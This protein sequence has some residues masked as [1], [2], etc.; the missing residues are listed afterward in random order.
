MRKL[1]MMQLIER[2][3]GDPSMGK[4]YAEWLELESV[5]GNKDALMRENGALLQERVTD[6]YRKLFAPGIKGTDYF[7]L[8]EALIESVNEYAMVKE[9]ALA[10]VGLGPMV[11]LLLEAPR[12]PEMMQFYTLKAVNKMVEGSAALMGMLSDCGGI[13]P[14]TLFIS[15]P[16]LDVIDEVITFFEQM[17]DKN[18]DLF[19]GC[20]GVHYILTLLRAVYKIPDYGA[21]FTVSVLRIVLDTLEAE[22]G[23]PHCDVARTYLREGFLTTLIGIGR[24]LKGNPEAGNLVGAS[25]LAMARSDE[26]V[27]AS[28]CRAEII[29]GVWELL[30]KGTETFRVSLLKAVELIACARENVEM[31]A[32]EGAVKVLFD[33]LPKCSDSPSLRKHI[34]AALKNIVSLDAERQ[35]ELVSLGIVP[36]LCRDVP[37][38]GLKDDV[39]PLLCSLLKAVKHRDEFKKS[40]VA[41]VLIA[42]FADQAYHQKAVESLAW[43]L[44]KD[45]S[46]VRPK[47]AHEKIMKALTATITHSNLWAQLMDSVLKMVKKSKTIAQKLGAQEAFVTFVLRKLKKSSTEQIRTLLEIVGVLCRRAKTNSDFVTKNNIVEKLTSLREIHASKVV[48][49]SSIDDLIDSIKEKQ[50]EMK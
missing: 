31:L 3:G 37:E 18:L 38:P 8:L 34:F 10:Q 36:Y 35:C 12:K 19:L 7:R 5:A 30:N 46:Y 25:L 20:N 40:N 49:A 28:M 11:E 4:D 2:D 21:G 47:I 50:N 9:A 16:S 15:S 32:R 23:R 24:G 6:I 1:T 17:S 45:S 29:T 14:I 42:L 48:V 13:I 44:E 27:K 22:K 39:I 33:Q 26:V 43:W 41:E